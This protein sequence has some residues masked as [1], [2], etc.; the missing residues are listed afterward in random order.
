MLPERNASAFVQWLLGCVI[1]TS[2]RV[3]PVSRSGLHSPKSFS[4][5]RWSN[6]WQNCDALQWVREVLLRDRVPNGDQWI[7][8]LTDFESTDEAGEH[9]GLGRREVVFGSE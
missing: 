1:I 9:V 2:V 8:H 4:T 7:N 3:R 5:D 6:P